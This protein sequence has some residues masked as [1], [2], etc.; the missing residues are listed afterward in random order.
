MLTRTKSR[1]QMFEEVK[2]SLF[3]QMCEWATTKYERIKQNTT[4]TNM[5]PQTFFKTQTFCPRLQ[6]N[7]NIAFPDSRTSHCPALTN[8]AVEWRH[9]HGKHYPG[10]PP[11]HWKHNGMGKKYCIFSTA[12][13]H[14]QI[15][16]YGGQLLTRWPIAAGRISAGCRRHPADN[17]LH[18]S[19]GQLPAVYLV[20][21]YCASR[22]WSNCLKQ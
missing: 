13:Q 1:T 8:D 5:K 19:M 14:V 10:P 11:C 16:A 21:W 18:Y 7:G 12:G 20:L 6:Q 15:T 22:Q 9:W 2:P 4:N 3:A 17:P